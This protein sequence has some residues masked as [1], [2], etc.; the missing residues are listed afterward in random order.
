MLYGLTVLCT[1]LS[2]TAL[3][4]FFSLTMTGKRKVLFVILFSLSVPAVLLPLDLLNIA[5]ITEGHILRSLSAMFLSFLLIRIF[6]EETIVKEIVIFAVGITFSQMCNLLISVPLAKSGFFEASIPQT[7]LTPNFLIAQ[8]L[9]TFAYALSIFLV[10]ALLKRRNAIYHEGWKLLCLFMIVQIIL[11]LCY[12]LGTES[13]LS[14]ETVYENI[15]LAVICMAADLSIFYVISEVDKKAALEAAA[16][17]YKNQLSMQ[18][19]LYENFSAYGESLRQ[20]KQDLVESLSQAQQS[21]KNRDYSSA[22]KMLKPLPQELEKLRTISYCEHRIVNALL[23]VKQRKMKQY[24]ISFD[25]RVRLAEDCFVE[26]SHLCRIL[27]NLLD[28]AIEACREIPNAEIHLTCMP[29]KDTLLMKTEN[30]VSGSIPIQKNGLP[31]STKKEFGHG[32]GL[33]SVKEIVDRYHGELRIEQKSSMFLVSVALFQK[34]GGK[35]EC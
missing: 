20:T 2:N 15:R 11:G 30:P 29:V 16:E 9:T 33:A 22:E 21:L 23:F 35:G 12:A 17:F 14:S 28:N 8:Y 34:T 13:D 27:S 32:K 19:S 7:E 24:G 26:S 4:I 25:C 5:E 1:T 18:L 10:A 31:A 6:F 3:A